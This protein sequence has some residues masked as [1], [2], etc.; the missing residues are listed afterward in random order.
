MGE[1]NVSP[2]KEYFKKD[3]EALSHSTP[4]P[5]PQSEGSQPVFPS[6]HRRSSG[7]CRTILRNCRGNLFSVSPAGTGFSTEQPCKKTELG[8]TVLPRRQID[9]AGCSQISEQNCK[10]SLSGL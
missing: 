8:K 4:L 2:S 1:L 10:N 3:R 6:L 5:F 9:C 7:I